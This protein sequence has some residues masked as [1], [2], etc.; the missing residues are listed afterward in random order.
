MILIC[1]SFFLFPSLH[2]TLCLCLTQLDKGSM[3][4]ADQIGLILA[5]LDSVASAADR[6]Q[7]EALK[8]VASMGIQTQT[9][10]SNLDQLV[11]L[12]ELIYQPK[13]LH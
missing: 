9:S 12:G 2:Q 11:C 1:F 7:K 10:A 8:Q 13:L 6:I 4:L 3:L 5:P